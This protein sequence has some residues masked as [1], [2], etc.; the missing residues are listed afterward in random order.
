MAGYVPIVIGVVITGSIGLISVLFKTC[1]TIPNKSKPDNLALPLVHLFND[2]N[3][4][5]CKPFNKSFWIGLFKN[6]DLSFFEL[7]FLPPTVPILSSF[8]PMECKHWD[9]M[10]IHHPGPLY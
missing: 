10:K 9:N 4:I 7:C 3:P 8:L 2:L 6:H 5:D 1:P